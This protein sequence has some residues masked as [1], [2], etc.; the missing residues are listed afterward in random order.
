DQYVRDY[1]R[2]FGV[3]TV[4]FRMSCVYGT[5]QFGTED[6]GWVAH[7]ARA[8]LTGKPITIYGDGCQV[9][10]LLWVGDLVDAMQSALT[11][12]EEQPGEVFNIGGGREN[13]VSVRTVIHR[14]EE[15]TGSEVSLETAEWR[16]GDQRIYVS[17]TAKA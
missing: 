16:P 11:K 9:R 3:P 1:A 7:F 12:A 4:V 8:I 13:A 6:Q 17:D 14:L 15:I 10:D 2:I 5:R